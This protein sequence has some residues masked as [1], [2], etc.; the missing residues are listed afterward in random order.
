MTKILMT[1]NDDSNSTKIVDSLFFDI[2]IFGFKFLF[3][4]SGFVIRICR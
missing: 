2:G 4:I 1:K 3:R